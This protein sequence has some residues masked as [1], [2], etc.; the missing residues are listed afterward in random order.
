VADLSSAP[1]AVQKTLIAVARPDR[2]FFDRCI[3]AL[4]TYCDHHDLNFVVHPVSETSNPESLLAAG[5][6]ENTGFLVFSYKL[7]EI[8]QKL[9]D[10]GRRIVLVGAPPAGKSLAMPSVFNDHK[11][12]GYLVAR[13]LIGLGHRRIASWQTVDSRLVTIERRWQGYQRAIAEARLSGIQVHWDVLACDEAW[14]AEPSLATAWFSRPEAPTALVAW[15]DADAVRLLFTLARAGIDVPGQVSV[16]GYDDL[17]EGNL[18][19]PPLTTVHHGIEQQIDAAVDILFSEEVWER[20]QTVIV[21]NLVE[22]SSTSAPKS[23]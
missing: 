1:E 16:T 8:A 2:S 12:G 22:R 4:Y 13:H 9:R 14:E 23:S 17:P 6:K 21:P 7:H 18:A 20:L 10:A 3:Q 19:Y 11:Y 15:N 5:D